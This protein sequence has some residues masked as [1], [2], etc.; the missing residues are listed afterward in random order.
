MPDEL[1]NWAGFDGHIDYEE[2][3]II[4]YGPKCKKTIPIYKNDILYY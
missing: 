4:R 1:I 2:V 3:L